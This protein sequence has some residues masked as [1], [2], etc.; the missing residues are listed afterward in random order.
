MKIKVASLF[1]GCGGLDFGFHADPHF[2]IIF[3][4]DSDKDACGSY[5][6][7]YEHTPI[8]KD[9][10][11]VQ[12]IPDCDIMLGGF[13]CQGF[14]IANPK[15]NK[16]DERNELYL[17]L[18]RLLKLKNPACF[19]FENV[20]GIMSLDKGIIFE[21]IL[22]EL[23]DCGYEVYTKLFKM[24]NYGVP[25]NRER[26]I[27]LGIRKDHGAQV[28]FEWPKE[29]LTLTLTLRETIGDLPLKYDES[30]QHIGSKN[31]VRVNG[32]VGGR[33]LDWDKISPTIIGGRKGGGFISP[34]HPSQERRLTVRE[35]ARIQTFPDD[36]EF[37]G[38]MTSMYRQ[39]GNAV[40]PK[41]SVILSSL[42]K[43]LIPI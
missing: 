3:A 17:E 1:S 36:F 31:K 39:I 21:N 32:Y 12:T 16:K 9:I 40:P 43:V 23:R 4:L 8:C 6:N 5:Q 34:I 13:P 18:V 28:N 22:L 2:E 27:I 41:F 33:V 19:V 14:S 7:Y 29:T 15:R 37:K 25:Q 30:I 26:V 10:R 35:V 24:K 20:K 38:S 11:K 42:V